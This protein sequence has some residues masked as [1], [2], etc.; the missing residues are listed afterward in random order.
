MSSLKGR[1]VDDGG[2]RAPFPSLSF[3]AVSSV[4]LCHF[5]CLGVLRSEMSGSDI[6]CLSSHLDM[7]F[8]WFGFF[9]HILC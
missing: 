4:D 3:P 6:G 2:K 8:V 1:D 5:L 9:A 7:F